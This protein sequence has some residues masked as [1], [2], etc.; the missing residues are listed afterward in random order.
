[1]LADNAVA[2]IVVDDEPSLLTVVLVEESA[3][4]AAV[5]V[6]VVVDTALP[7]QLARKTVD[8]NSNEDVSEIVNLKLE[9]TEFPR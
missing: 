2:V 4:R 1:L 5:A 6:A 9:R 7:P 3:I 8:N